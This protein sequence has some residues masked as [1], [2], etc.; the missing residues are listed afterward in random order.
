MGERVAVEACAHEHNVRSE[1]G[2]GATYEVVGWHRVRGT[3]RR[4][5]EAIN[6]LVAESH[7]MIVLFKGAW[8]S[9]PGSPWGYTSG[10]EEELFTGLLELAQADQPMRDVWVGFVEASDVDEQ[11]LSLRE[12]LIRRHS[13]MF[14]SIS[15]VRD[16]KKKLADRLRSW[17]EL[18]VPKTPRYVELLPSSGKDVLRAANLRLQGEKLV[19]LGQPKAGRDCL[20]EAATLGGPAEV[21]AYAR[22]LRRAGDL[23]EAYDA[24][25]EAIRHLTANAHLHSSLAAEAFSAQ[26]R[27]LSAQ[28][29][30]RDAV[31][32]LEHALTLAAGDDAYSRSVR[33]RIHDDI[34]LGYMKVDEIARARGNFQ[35]ALEIRRAMD[36]GNDYAQS[37]INLA[38]IEVAVGEL[39][40][41][42][43]HA[44]EAVETLR[45]TPPSA[46]RANGELL[47][48]QV[49]LRQGRPRE[50]ISHAEWALAMNRQIANRRGEAISLLVLAQCCRE[51]GDLADA[52]RHA[53]ACL[54]ANESMGNTG[55]AGKAQWIL[56]QLSERCGR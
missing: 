14:E 25:A 35:A 13:M 17:G 49:R 4:P 36:S 28:G 40:A 22:I 26:A 54:A 12:Q 11:I 27:V 33:A 1:L 55:G 9:A 38:R 15:D 3:A 24:T 45:G 30:H 18:P 44:D 20:K 21:L 23:D 41:A 46:L 29:R 43:E 53:Q 52:E 34:G 16:L 19:E 39:A 32:R 37:L 8:G 31:G 48:A 6:E 42:A 5:Q 47:A 7:F 2:S 51:V 50:G 56:D 10:T